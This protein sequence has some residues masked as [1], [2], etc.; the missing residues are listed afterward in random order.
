MLLRVC[1]RFSSQTVVKSAGETMFLTY[2][3]QVKVIKHSKFLLECANNYD[4]TRIINT[5]G[6]G[7]HTP[8]R[9]TPIRTESKTTTAGY[10]P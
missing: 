2:T 4:S 7:T 9:K 3:E 8:R 10:Q 6:I 5:V 1:A